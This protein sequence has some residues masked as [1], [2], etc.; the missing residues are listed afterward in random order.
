MKIAKK[1][2]NMRRFLPYYKKYMPWVILDLL[3]AG[4]T[5]VC[6]IVFPLIVRYLTDLGI[7]GLS[8]QI[9]VTAV[10][11][12][13]VLR[14]IDGLAYYFMSNQGHIIGA[15]VETDMRTDL[16]KHLQRLSFSYYSD[17]KIGQIM[18]RMTSD[19]FDVTEFSHHFPEELF[20]GALKIVASFIILCTINVPLTIIMFLSFPI[21]FFISVKFNF[22]QRRA[23][24]NQRFRLGEINAQTEDSLLGIRVVKS[25]ARE[26]KEVEKFENGN[27]EFL[28]TKKI[29]YK[30]L[31]IFHSLTRAFDGLMYIV[32]VGFGAYFLM[33]GSISPAD[34]TAYL[35]FTSMLIASIR[36]FVE[37]SEQFQRG[38]TGI[39]RFYEIMDIEPDIK[40][41]LNAEK[42]VDVE[43]NV[44]FDNVAFKYEGEKTEVLDNINLNIK[45]G[46]HVAIVGPSGAGKT[47]LCNLI[48]RF[49]EV[50]EGRVLI[51]GKN[52]RDLTVKSLR[53]NIGV[54]QQDVY[55]FSGTVFDNIAYGKEN[56]TME[57][58]IQASKLAGADDFIL[59]LP[60]GYNTFVGERGVKLSGGQKQR[61][62]IARVFLKN[63]KILILDEA[64]SALDNE[65]EY[66]V[67]QSLEKLAKG[68][69]TFTVAHRLTTIQNAD[70]ILVLT[71]KGVVEEGTHFELLEKGGV[72]AK[73]YS[74]FSKL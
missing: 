5:T 8:V 16:F 27:L 12:Y 1:K 7:S 45:A 51:D 15:K 10:G 66:I 22:K 31:G 74:H 56:A 36:R 26:D 30:Y 20:I 41:S 13:V 9:I 50:S 54:V 23:F 3:C 72:Y 11:L 63:P 42:L 33:K 49:Y 19:L 35:L 53:E 61:I 59:A 6:E 67:Q 43:G 2:G 69:T 64:T 62:S 25:F 39:D 58:V 55:L 28:N 38:M 34:L 29:S 46:T 73:L 57:E 18:A 60:N 21:I 32:V 4:L 24:A 47:T 71:E 65:S 37:F 44:V 48:P 70:I 40:D 17:A 68:R 52:V 14:I